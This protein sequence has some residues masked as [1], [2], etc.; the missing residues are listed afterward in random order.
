MAGKPF[1]VTSQAQVGRSSDGKFT[2]LVGTAP[3]QIIDES[4]D[5]GIRMNEVIREKAVPDRLV[6]TAPPKNV[7]GPRAEAKAP[8]Y[9]DAI[10][11][12]KS[13][14]VNDGNRKPFKV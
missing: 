4:V 6:G 9:P 3:P 14:P 1:R 7:A 12:P 2:R 8:V 11:W 13:G 5:R 10:P